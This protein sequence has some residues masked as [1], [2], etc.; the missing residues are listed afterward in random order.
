MPSWPLRLAWQLPLLLRLT[1]KSRLNQAPSR[2]LFNN[3]LKVPRL[4][5]I[6]RCRA[7]SNPK[8][9]LWLPR[10]L[11][12]NRLK[13]LTLKNRTTTTI[14]RNTTRNPIRREETKSTPTPL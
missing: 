9:R 2:R 12:V 7:K 10:K 13:K 4:K 1:L 5:L 14:L 8:S 3:Q 11:R 6:V